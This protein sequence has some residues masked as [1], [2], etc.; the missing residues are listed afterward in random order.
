MGEFIMIHLEFDTAR[1][2]EVH[3]HKNYEMIY[4]VDG[5]CTVVLDDT[6]VRLKPGEFTIVNSGQKHGYN[7]G[8]G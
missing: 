4:V 7:L 2:R 8:G 3:S 5:S 1:A 6:L